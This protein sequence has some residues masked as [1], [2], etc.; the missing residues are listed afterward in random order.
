M[1]A[2]KLLLRVTSASELPKAP[3]ESDNVDAEREL[4]ATSYGIASDPITKFAIVFSALIH[5]AD[6][7]GVPN[8][9]LV[10]ENT[11]IAAIYKGK[12]VAEQNSVDLAWGLLMDP[13]YRALRRAICETPEEMQRFRSVV[14]N[15]VLATDI[16]DKELGELRKKRWETAFSEETNLMEQNPRENI[17]RKATLVIEHIIQASD[18]AH[19]L[20]VCP[21]LV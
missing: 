16:G 19:T 3:P 9:Q 5:D 8:S 17:N 18:V 13:K 7:A 14:I 6:H 20:Q 12:S 15:C 11:E 1:N 21:S 4:H 10:Q 2:V